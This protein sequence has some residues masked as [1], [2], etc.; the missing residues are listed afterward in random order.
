LTAQSRLAERYAG[1]RREK[2][3]TEYKTGWRKKSRARNRTDWQFLLRAQSAPYI[4]RKLPRKI[5]TLRQQKTPK[6][7]TKKSARIEQ[8]WLARYW[9][10]RWTRKGVQF[11]AE[12]W[13]RNNWV[14]EN[15]KEAFNEGF[16]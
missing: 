6:P 14:S 3:N 4:A 2:P 15:E 16:V 8:Q 11:L 10:S 9:R 1:S 12:F 13:S 5:I 7:H